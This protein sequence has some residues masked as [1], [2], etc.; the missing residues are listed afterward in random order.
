MRREGNQDEGSNSRLVPIGVSGI[1]RRH[2]VPIALSTRSLLFTIHL[3]SDSRVLFKH[4]PD[5][6]NVVEEARSKTKV[7]PA[8]ALRS[9][10]EE[11]L[12]AK[13][14]A[15]A[16]YRGLLQ[17]YEAAKSEERRVGEEEENLVKRLEAQKNSL[18]KKV[19]ILV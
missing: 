3:H 1:T 9:Q 16:E 15:E 8:N 2:T 19:P 13:Q 12:G 14:V 6:I 10:K 5:F 17:Q 11:V 4:T 7:A 18:K